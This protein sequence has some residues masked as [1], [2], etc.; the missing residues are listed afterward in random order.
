M[1]RDEVCM[2]AFNQGY[3]IAENNPKL[4]KE[5][6]SS[7]EA[8]TDYSVGFNLGVKASRDKGKKKDKGFQI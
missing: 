1:T 6:K 2:A 7:M 3:I 5:V 8:K 4:L